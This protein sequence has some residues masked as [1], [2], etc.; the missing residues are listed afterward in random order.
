MDKILLEIVP[1]GP[2][3]NTSTLPDNDLA[4]ANDG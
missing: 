4:P 3:S 2:I 1:K